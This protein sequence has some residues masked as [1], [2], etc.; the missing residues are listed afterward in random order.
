MLL[1]GFLAVVAMALGAQVWRHKRRRRRA[2]YINA[3]RFDSAYRQALRFRYPDLTDTDLKRAEKALRQFFLMHLLQPTAQLHMPSRLADALWHAFILDTRRYLPFCKQAFGQPFHHIPSHAMVQPA[4]EQ[5]RSAMQATWNAAVQT[6]RWMPGA[7]LAGV[8]LLFA[9]DAAA[10][11][12]DGMVYSDAD[13]RYWAVALA[14]V[15]GGGTNG[16]ASSDTSSSS[17]YSS[18]DTAHP[19]YGTSSSNSSDCSSSSSAASDSSSSS[20]DSSSSSSCGGGCGGGSS[21]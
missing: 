11:I 17:N 3:Y 20:C 1:W 14:Q 9:L 7:V 5:R 16:V 12:S 4:P 13:V 6:K 10:Q 8:P 2:A 19:M 18:S 15:M 21:D